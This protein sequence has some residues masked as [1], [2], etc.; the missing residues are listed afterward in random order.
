MKWKRPGGWYFRAV[1]KKT[2]GMCEAPVYKSSMTMRSTRS[3]VIWW[4]SALAKERLLYPSGWEWPTPRNRVSYTPSRSALEGPEPNTAQ[5]GGAAENL[6]IL[7]RKVRWYRLDDVIQVVPEQLPDRLEGEESEPVRGVLA[8]V[9]RSSLMFL[10]A[11]GLLYRDCD[12]FYNLLL[13]GGFIIIDDYADRRDFR[14]KT[15]RYPLGG[16]KGYRTFVFLSYFME[17]RLF[18]RIE[19]VGKTM[20]GRKPRDRTGDVE[21]DR[22]EID[23]QRRRIEV[24]RNRVLDGSKAVSERSVLSAEVALGKFTSALFIYE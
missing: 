17:K 14:P 4:R 7:L 10:D 12:Y 21:F 1:K 24:E 18:E 2:N 5:Y 20:F 22:E 19:M 16:G 8:N 6:D 23:L 15:E 9:E 11:D 13:P 3:R